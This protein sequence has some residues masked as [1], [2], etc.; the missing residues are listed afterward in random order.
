V[1]F[2]ALQKL[3]ASALNALL[4]IGVMKQTNEDVS[5]ATTGTTLQDDNELQVTVAANSVYWVDVMVEYAEA[6]GTGVDI[7]IAWTQPSGCTLNLGVVG[8]HANWT[9]S[10]TANLEV[11]WNAWRNETGSP[12]NFRN[13]GSIN[14]IQFSLHFRGTLQVGNTGGKFGMQWAQVNLS[15]TLLTVYAGSAMQLQPILTP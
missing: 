13:F 4:P 6:A 3:R 2:Y 15:A 5:S 12:T 11:E 10:P 8:P 7:K 14:G 1:T 9:S